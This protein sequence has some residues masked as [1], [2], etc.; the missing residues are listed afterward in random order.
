MEAFALI[1]GMQ[2]KM[3]DDKYLIRKCL[4]NDDIELSN[5]SY[6]SVEIFSTNELLEAW[7]EK[8]LIPKKEL[9]IQLLP[10]LMDP[11]LISDEENKI[12]ENR[13][14]VLEPVIKGY[15]KP[16]DI[17][18]YVDSLPV[19]LKLSIS[20]VS[21]LYKWKKKYL[22][23]GDKRSLISTGRYQK[24]GFYTD[25]IIISLIEKMLRDEER[26]GLTTTI[27]DKHINLKGSIEDLNKFREEKDQIKPCGLATLFRIVQDRTNSRAKDRSRHGPVQAALNMNGST[28]ELVVKRP[29]ERVEVDWTP[30]DLLIVDLE[31]LKR[32]RYYL[33]Y[34]I[35]V[36]SDYP[37][38]FYICPNEPDTKD[39]LQCLLHAM[40]PKLHL[41]KL[42]PDLKHDWTA[43]GVPEVV[44]VDNAKANESGD[45][46]EIL[47]LINVEVQFCPVKT[48]HY[49][50]TIERGLQTINRILQKYPGSTF[51]NPQ[52][53]SQ[54][55][56]EEEA[57]ID[58]LTLL[59]IIHIIFIEKIANDYSLAVGGTPDFVWREGLKKL[60]VHRRIPFS[61][62]EL[63]ILLGS[64][65]E[66]RSIS[67]KGIKIQ[68]QYF[69]SPSLMELA[70]RKKRR[71][72]EEDV[73]VRFNKADMRI[74]YVYDEENQQYIEV[75]S[76]KN[77]LQNKNIN[78]LYPVHYEQLHSISY[79]NGKNYRDFDTSD[80]YHADQAIKR[81]ITES[82]GRLK[83]VEQL[84]KDERS[85]IMSKNLSAAHVTF[86]AQL[87]PNDLE[88]IRLVDEASEHIKDY[89]EKFKRK[90]KSKATT[91]DKN[92][93]NKKSSFK[94]PS[95]E[96]ATIV[97]TSLEMEL[98]PYDTI[99]NM[100]GEGDE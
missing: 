35:D 69:T 11:E 89:K 9:T 80:L 63:I 12:M 96:Q 40:L 55:K 28:S 51:S 81:L 48:G 42:Y 36:F 87:A 88:S 86:D 30:I 92:T 58:M 16:A 10:R 6:N 57:C 23:T 14:K 72:D 17:G 98:K 70:D 82:A 94:T 56:S 22:E 100:N 66:Y 50:G 25:P 73:R 7:Y 91:S 20:S 93:G 79:N 2:F 18:N 37:L 1:P 38:G 53:R 3:D 47:G 31:T 99:Y 84:P 5:L 74:I 15:I 4:E 27:R 41:K 64:G 75:Y 85:E 45:L 83:V 95:V 76:T 33:I 77:S 97:D 52:E 90:R 39:I 21:M 78:D 44:V 26:T 67:N 34:A 32:V 43:F 68:S 59:N 46:K 29:L 8:R 71:K 49:K 19:E 65:T 24:R 60:K 54:Y 62:E 13:F 61:K